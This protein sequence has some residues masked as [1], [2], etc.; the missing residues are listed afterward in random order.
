MLLDAQEFRGTLFNCPSCGEQQGKVPRA[1]APGDIEL[2]KAC[3]IRN[4]REATS[5]A[6]M[7]FVQAG[8]PMQLNDLLRRQQLLTAT[9]HF[10]QALEIQERVTQVLD[11]E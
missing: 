5:A 11:V 6:G 4:K 2:M 9:R 7:S 8:T 3:A 1:M 10:Q